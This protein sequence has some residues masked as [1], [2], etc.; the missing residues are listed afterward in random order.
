MTTFR[1]AGP[2]DARA[3][4]RLYELTGQRPVGVGIWAD[5]ATLARELASL[6]RLWAVAEDARGLRAV[7]SLTLEPDNRIAK[8]Y[9][10]FTMAVWEERRALLSG[11][12]RVA[13][14]AVLDRDMADVVYCTART[15]N[16]ADQLLTLEH[17]FE[18]I[19]I[20][21]NAPSA[22]GQKVSG[23]AA[24]YAE[25][26]LDKRYVDYA[27]HPA[28][29][30]FFDL[31]RKRLGFADLPSAGP[32]TMPDAGQALPP[33]EVIQAPQFAAE[34]FRQLKERSKL[35]V[36]FYPFQAP[37]VLVTSPDRSVQVFAAVPPELRFAAIIGEHLRASVHPVALYRAVSGLLRQTGAAYIEVINDASD[38]LGIECILRAGF[39]PCGYFPALK[40]ADDV[41]RDFVVFARSLEPVDAAHA[42]MPDAFAGYLEE[43][44]AATLKR[45]DI[46]EVR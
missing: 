42:A 28:V 43:F 41:R 2:S 31:A 16:S 7:A 32:L 40:S 3:L 4:K 10:L 6:K 22:D 34:Q 1:L 44:L 37:N 24:W 13:M 45:G 9:R 25:G 12:L 39:S 19:G 5:E 30:P 35:S 36:N 17:G 8:L 29:R 23:L 15:I 11:C 18:A 46:Q 33:L 26:V 38:V 21:P 14:K 20:F 27:M